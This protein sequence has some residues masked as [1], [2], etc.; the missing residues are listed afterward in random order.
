MNNANYSIIPQPHGAEAIVSHGRQRV[1]VWAPDD[2]QAEQLAKLIIARYEEGD[3]PL[4]AACAAV[5]HG[6]G[7]YANL[8]SE[9]L[10]ATGEPD[11]PTA[12]GFDYT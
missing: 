10:Q 8:L 9:A 7:P 12:T 2:Q 6:A 3:L 4:A 5:H 11:I 1:V